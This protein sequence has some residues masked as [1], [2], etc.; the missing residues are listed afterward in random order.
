MSLS[1]TITTE[2]QIGSELLTYTQTPT[3]LDGGCPIDVSIPNSTTNGVVNFHADVSQTKVL[4]I[5]CDKAITLNF[6]SPAIGPD[7]VGTGFVFGATTIT[8]NDGAAWS[9]SAALGDYV[10]ITNAEDAAN[11]GTFG[12]ITAVATGNDGSITIGSASF[13]TNSDDQSAVFRLGNNFTLVATIP[14][15]WVSGDA[16]SN[17]LTVDVKTLFVTNT[18]GAAAALKIR[19]FEDAAPGF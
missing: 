3:G 7:A 4:V 13:T 8:R 15:K 10:I 6:N 1:A 19:Y 11:N 18:S 2:V 17:P 5:S 16:G 14:I 12:P 9:T